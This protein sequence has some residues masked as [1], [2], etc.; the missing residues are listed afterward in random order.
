MFRKPL[1][2]FLLIAAVLNSVLVFGVVAAQDATATPVPLPHW[3]YEGEEGPAHWGGLDSRFALCAS[4]QSQSPIDILAPASQNLPDIQFNYQPSALTILNNGHTVQVNYD[5]GSSITIDGTEYALKQFHFHHPSEHTIEGVTYPMEMHL[6][7]ADAN[8][9]LA[10]VGIMIKEGEADN[11]ALAPVFENMPTQK[12]DAQTIADVTVN[13]ADMLPDSHL[14]YGYSGSLTTPP[15]SENV[16]WM[17]LTTPITLSVEQI[18]K[19]AGA[20]ELDARP[21]QPLNG[22]DLSVDSGADS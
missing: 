2:V 16:K 6:V 8:G 21:V 7:H 22:R 9:N 4:G 19:F 11:A 17:V 15:C 14:Y 5:A 1:L 18:E 12:A 10:V 20:F 13:A 3:T